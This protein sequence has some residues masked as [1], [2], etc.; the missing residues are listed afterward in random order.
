M[1]DWLTSKLK[2]K[3]TI[4]TPGIPAGELPMPDLDRA[5]GD[6]Q[7]LRSEQERLRR[8]MAEE[9][10]KQ[11][12]AARDKRARDEAAAEYEG[13]VP[14]R[15]KTPEEILSSLPEKER[16]KYDKRIREGE[17]AKVEAEM[18][19]WE[20]GI[21]AKTKVM[22]RVWNPAQQ[23]WEFKEVEVPLTPQERLAEARIQ[24][25]G[26]M[27]VEEE[28]AGLKQRRRE[29]SIPYR[30]ARGAAGFG[31]L[32]AGTIAFGTAGVARGKEA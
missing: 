6:A 22:H 3:S 19:I 30:A 25:I 31:Q 2:R 10:V 4:S 7:R 9:E 16:K 5:Y 13:R 18:E 12:K 21:P 27:L 29:R 11:E 23:T 28:V 15:T 26:G 17:R 20:A 24:K 14:P 8:T 1:F 32:M